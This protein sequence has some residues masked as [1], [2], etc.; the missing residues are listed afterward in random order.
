MWR[1]RWFAAAA[2]VTLGLAIGIGNTVYT[3]VNAMIL[4]GLPV[5]HPDRIVMFTDGTPDPLVLNVSYRDVADWRQAASTFADIGLFTSTTLTI[6]DD[7]RA[8]DVVGGSFVSTNI[9]RVVEQP[10]LLGRDFNPGD[11]QPGAAPVV[12]LGYAVWASRYGSDPTIVGRTV[13]VN[14]R[15]T[16]VVG[17]MP[18]GSDFRSSTISGPR[19]PP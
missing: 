9:F 6:G 3:V 15:P 7:G 13:R 19:C 14:G 8:P 11:E 17:V 10:P 1:R 12:I 2:V 5:A 4:R 18:P 16:T